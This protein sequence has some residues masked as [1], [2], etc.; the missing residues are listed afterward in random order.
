MAGLGLSLSPLALDLRLP[1]AEFRYE[2]SV[3]PKGLLCR[4]CAQGSLVLLYLC[5]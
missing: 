3:P 4:S 5:M 2:A 1:M